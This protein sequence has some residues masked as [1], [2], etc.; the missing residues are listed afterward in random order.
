MFEHQL[1][2][3]LPVNTSIPDSPITSFQSENM[4]L[5][6]TKTAMITAAV[7]VSAATTISG[8]AKTMMKKTSNAANHSVTAASP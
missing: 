6:A 1:S 4:S 3:V 2:G 8:G 5:I 7:T